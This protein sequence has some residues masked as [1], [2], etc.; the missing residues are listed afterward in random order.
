M[1]L[2]RFLAN[3]STSPLDV[4]SFQMGQ[5]LLT[6]SLS[7]MNLTASVVKQALETIRALDLEKWSVRVFGQSMLSK[8][9]ALLSAEADDTKTA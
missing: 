6:I 7:T 5:M 9:K 4:P 3:T 8:R 2:N 1:S